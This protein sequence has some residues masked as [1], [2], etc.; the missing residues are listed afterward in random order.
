[1]YWYS[2]C[3]VVLQSVF[4]EEQSLLKVDHLVITYIIKEITVSVSVVQL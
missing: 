1:M 3:P 2:D 4:V